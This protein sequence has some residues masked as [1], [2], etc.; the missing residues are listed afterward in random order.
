[1]GQSHH[2]PES[3]TEDIA[4]P[5]LDPDF[6]ITERDPTRLHAFAR[7]LLTRLRKPSRA[8][9]KQK[10]TAAAVWLIDAYVDAQI[11]LAPEMAE[12]ISRIVK[13]DRRAT[14]FRKVQAP[15]DK[16]YWAA[17]HFEAS[18]LPDPKSKRPSAA[19]VYSVAKHVLKTTGLELQGTRIPKNFDSE[20]AP[21]TAQKSAEATIRGWRKIDHYQQNVRLQRKF[22][23]DFME[24]PV[25]T[26]THGVKK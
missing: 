8:F 7:G 15:N 21:N 26:S 4:F 10:V 12:V 6:L 20:P 9:S 3:T 1:L 17:I 13:W 14:T 23:S 16:A 22:S 11:P 2:I 5:V 19:S 24:I 25:L 18:C